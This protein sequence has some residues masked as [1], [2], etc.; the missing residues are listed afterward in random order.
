VKGWLC[1]ACRGELI[2][3][4]CQ[5]PGC[6]DPRMCIACGAGC[7]LLTGGACAAADGWPGPQLRRS[8]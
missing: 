6:D 5:A 4:G 7:D 3:T 8:P 2:P 1:R